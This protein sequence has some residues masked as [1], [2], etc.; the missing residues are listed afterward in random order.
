MPDPRLQVVTDF[1]MPGLDGLE[2]A[3]AIHERS[4][5]L[6]VV[7]VTGSDL[8]G[9]DGKP[10]EL[11]ALLPKPY[12]PM[13]LLSAVRDALTV[14]AELSQQF[15]SCETSGGRGVNL[16]VAPFRRDFENH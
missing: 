9:T 5:D 13:A 14:R 8:E 11:Q 2:F 7:M 3:R 1:N 16:C 12:A 6:K 4:P 10:G 15:V